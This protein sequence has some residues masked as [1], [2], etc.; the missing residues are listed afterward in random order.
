MAAGNYKFVSFNICWS[1]RATG[2]YSEYSLVA[3]FHKIAQF[4]QDTNADI[5]FLQEVPSEWRG[6][7]ETLFPTHYWSWTNHPDRDARCWL[8]IGVRTSQIPLLEIHTLSCEYITGEVQ[9]IRA[10]TMLLINVHYPMKKE[11]RQALQCALAQILKGNLQSRPKSHVVVWGDMNTFADEGG[12]DELT[13]FARAS[14]TVHVQMEGDVSF[15]AYPYD[16][17]DAPVESIPLDNG[18]VANVAVSNKRFVHKDD[19]YMVTAEGTRWW[20]SDHFAT[21]AELQL[22]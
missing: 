15:A 9:I 6:V 16:K 13:E 2:P 10:G 1:R 7:V 14:G 20:C 3:R 11:R 4:L 21:V 12:A 18:F 17:F 8:A 5:M 22:L 19:F